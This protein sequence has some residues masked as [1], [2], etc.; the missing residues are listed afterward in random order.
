MLMSQIVEAVESLAISN[1]E[2]G[3]AAKPQDVALE[4]FFDGAEHLNCPANRSIVYYAYLNAYRN[5]TETI[6]DATYT[7]TETPGLEY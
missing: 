2:R 5:H 1:A 4:S 7:P 3:V 6:A